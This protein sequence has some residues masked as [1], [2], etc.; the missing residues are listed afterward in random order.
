LTI[1]TSRDGI[2]WTPAHQ[3]SVLGELIDGGLQSPHSLAAV[4]PFTPRDARYVRVRPVSELAEFAWYV[5][6][7][8][9][10]R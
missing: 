6:E 10:T 5:A 8:G 2:A 4:M 1:D 7:I 3:G 9:V